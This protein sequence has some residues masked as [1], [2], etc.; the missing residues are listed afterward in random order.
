M[1]IG[2]TGTKEGMTELQ[3]KTVC[4]I[5]LSF[6]NITTSSGKGLIHIELHH[7]DCVGADEDFHRIGLKLGVPR[8]VIHPPTNSKYRAHCDKIDSGDTI[9]VVEKEYSYLTRNKHIVDAG[10][11]VMIGTPKAEYEELRSGTWHAIRY[12]RK[13]H[14]PLVIVYPNGTT[15]FDYA[16]LKP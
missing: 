2:F 1:K 15:F 14:E 10:L 16:P 3:K 5:I 8:I 11:T 6:A 13:Q 9:V 12:T 4:E 7:G